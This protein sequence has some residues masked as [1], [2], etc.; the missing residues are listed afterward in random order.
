MGTL[1]LRLSLPISICVVTSVCFASATCIV[2]IRTP[3]SAVL[4][5][6]SRGTFVDSGNKETF[7]NVC[8]IDIDR[9]MATAVAGLTVNPD[10]GFDALEILVGRLRQQGSVHERVTGALDDLRKRL[11]AELGHQAD[12]RPVI[13]ARTTG[14]GAPITVFVIGVENGTPVLHVAS[15]RVSATDSESIDLEID[16]RS[17]PGD[18]C[19]NGT[20]TT[21]SG[22]TDSLRRFAKGSKVHKTPSEAALFFLGKLTEINDESCGVPSQVVETSSS[23]VRWRRTIPECKR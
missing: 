5:S 2:A 7:R 12:N 23:G 20:Y 4:A 19:P 11:A 17:C 21:W 9:D 10:T 3:Q 14:L 15:F 13:F 16:Y 18:D 1:C 22:K 8:K 6:D